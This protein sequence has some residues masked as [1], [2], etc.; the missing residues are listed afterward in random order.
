MLEIGHIKELSIFFVS[1][2]VSSISMNREPGKGW[3]LVRGCCYTP[4][5]YFDPF[6][7]GMAGFQSKK[8]Q[9]NNKYEIALCAFPSFGI[10]TFPPKRYFCWPFEN[11]LSKGKNIWKV[12]LFICLFSAPSFSIT[13]SLS[14]FL[15]SIEPGFT[16]PYQFIYRFASE[17]N[18]CDW[19]CKP[20]VI[21][22]NNKI[23]Y[24]MYAHSTF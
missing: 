19:S 2:P 13:F 12:I 21:C 8:G 4:S 18:K 15:S 10:K 22:C 20:S 16:R 1:C 17:H 11:Y 6:W 9:L 3:I 5:V 14:L 24:R 23:G 7:D